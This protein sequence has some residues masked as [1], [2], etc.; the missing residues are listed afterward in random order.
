MKLVWLRVVKFITRSSIKQE[1]E[2]IIRE[3]WVTREST[4]L[5]CHTKV[6][7][8]V[9][10]NRTKKATKENPE[11]ANFGIYF[12]RESPRDWNLKRQGIRA[13]TPNFTLEST[14]RRLLCHSLYMFDTLTS[15]PNHARMSLRMKKTKRKVYL[16][17]KRYLSSWRQTQKS[18]NIVKSVK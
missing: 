4:E 12:I 9:H 3:D 11:V 13:K 1:E 14:S 2:E 18:R 6:H 5:V 16:C 8:K 10:T 15:S 7:T 17:H